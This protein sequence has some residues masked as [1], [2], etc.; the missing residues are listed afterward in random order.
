MLK[1][2]SGGKKKRK[3]GTVQFPHR[4]LSRLGKYELTQFSNFFFKQREVNLVTDVSDLTYE[5]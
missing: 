3:E 4:K 1:D 2:L 5:L